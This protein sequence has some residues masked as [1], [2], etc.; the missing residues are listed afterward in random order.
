MHTLRITFLGLIMVA[1]VQVGCL[2]TAGEQTAVQSPVPPTKVAP[3][4]TPEAVGLTPTPVALTATVAVA[5]STPPP[6][7]EWP[8]YLTIELV[9]DGFTAPLALAA[10]D[11]ETGRLFIADQVGQI[12]I[13]L[14]DGTRLEDPLLDLSA[15]LVELRNGYDERGLL[16]LALHPDFSENGRFYVYYSASLPLEKQ[17]SLDHTSHIS[18]FTISETDINSADP[19]SERLILQIDQPYYSHN[20]GQLAFGPDGYLYVGVGDGGYTDTVANSHLPLGHSQDKETL[21]GTVLR[22]DVDQ[23]EKIAAAGNPFLGS[24]GRD[25]IFA[26]GLRNPYRFSF[27]AAGDNQ[28]FLGDVGH[29]SR[30]EINLITKGANYGWPLQEGSGCFDFE[31]EIADETLCN[32]PNEAEEA[33][34]PPVYEYD[35][36]NGRSVIGGYVYRGTTIPELYG[37]YLFADWVTNRGKDYTLLIGDAAEAASGQWEVSEIAL[38]TASSALP[39]R[40][41]TLGFGQDA[42]HELYL[43]ATS[44]WTP[45]GTSGRVYRIISAP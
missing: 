1:M 9:T 37:A 6:P 34:I 25:E 21:L 39:T 38:Q 12:Y 10:P 5:A 18:E 35:H 17:G 23:E 11:D 24:D 42:N 40:F 8:A 15:Q 33:F 30:E 27:D 31:L 28:L 36:E 45:S 29:D 4:A 26:L 32:S 14:A 20:G 16:G 2:A 43:L 13:V 19:A 44:G 7:A 41:Y 22:L 3:S